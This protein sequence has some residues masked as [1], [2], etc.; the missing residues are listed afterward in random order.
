MEEDKLGYLYIILAMFTWGSI[1][2]IVRLIVLSPQLIVF[3]RV[4]FAF[5][6]LLLLVLQDQELNLN[7]LFKKKLLL[8]ATGTALT[9]NWIFFFKAIKTTTIANA[10]LAYYTAPILATILSVIFLKEKLTKDNLFALLLSFVGII[11]ISDINNL[12]LSG[13]EGIGYGL[14]SAFFYASFMVLNKFLANLSARV[15]TLGQTG[16]AVLIL[17]PLVYN[18]TQPSGIETWLLL[19]VLGIIHTAGALVLYVKGLSLSKVQDVGV[20]SYLD[21]ISAIILAAL[22]LNEIPSLLTIVGGGLILIG[23]Y[24]VWRE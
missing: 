1:G 3:Y 24:L 16:I 20:L 7:N 4:L 17:L 5:T 13:L 22:F 9:I 2:L 18:G 11:I 12:S 10:T 21:P 6:F 23:C 19:L 8:I 14:L 15:L